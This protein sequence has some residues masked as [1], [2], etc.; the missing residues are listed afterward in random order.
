MLSLKS[1]YKGIISSA[2]TILAQKMLEAG[3][4][5]QKEASS[6]NVAEVPYNR[7][8][9]MDIRQATEAVGQEI[10]DFKQ[11]VKVVRETEILGET[12][13]LALF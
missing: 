9:L 13:Q 1:K 4:L 6:L 7:H 5:L 12:G 2:P 8:E 10:R 11:E 3:G